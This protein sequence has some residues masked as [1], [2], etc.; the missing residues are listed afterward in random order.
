[1]LILLAECQRMNLT[2]KRSSLTVSRYFLEFF[3]DYHLTRLA[4]A[5]EMEVKSLCDVVALVSHASKILIP[6]IL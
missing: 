1:M 4:K 3:G 6:I 5:S 2:C